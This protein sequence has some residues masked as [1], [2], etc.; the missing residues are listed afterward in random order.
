MER[1]GKYIIFTKDE[2]EKFSVDEV[3]SVEDAQEA[4]AVHTS[5][6][7]G[8]QL[9]ADCLIGDA[10]RE[11]QNQRAAHLHCAI[12][13]NTFASALGHLCAPTEVEQFINDIR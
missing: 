1:Q 6:A 2:Q 8:Q 3:M 11:A 13:L 9:R 5:N 12:E 10:S 7:H 4:A